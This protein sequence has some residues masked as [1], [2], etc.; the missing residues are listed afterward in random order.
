MYCYILF[1]ANK[2]YDDFA[3]DNPKEVG[4]YHPFYITDSPEGGF[5]QKN[6]VEQKKQRVFAGIMYDSDDYPLP[7]TG[8]K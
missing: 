1:I 8:N 7:T 5:G 3:G 6:E 2:T 4:H